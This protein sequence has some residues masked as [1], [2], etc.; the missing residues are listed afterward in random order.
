M[1]SLGGNEGNKPGI[2]FAL[3]AATCEIVGVHVRKCDRTRLQTSGGVS[4]R[5]K[6]P[7]LDGLVLGGAKERIGGG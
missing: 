4:V 5:Q 6:T 7:L 2:R 1:W 3:G